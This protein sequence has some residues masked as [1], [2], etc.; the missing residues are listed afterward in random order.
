[1]HVEVQY[2]YS[3]KRQNAAILVLF[4]VTFARLQNV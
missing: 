3:S 2:E 1:M 4:L